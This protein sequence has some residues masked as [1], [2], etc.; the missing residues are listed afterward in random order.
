MYGYC[1]IPTCAGTVRYLYM[2]VLYNTYMCRYCTIPTCADTVR[3]LFG[4]HCTI[5]ICAGTVR[6]QYVQVL[7][8]TNMCRY[9]IYMCRYCTI[10]ICTGTVQYLHV[11]VLYDIYMCRYCT[12]STC[13][14]TVR[15]QY[16]LSS[17]P[18]SSTSANTREIS[19]SG[20]PLHIPEFIKWKY[21]LL[22]K[23]SH[24]PAVNLNVARLNLYSIW[25]DCNLQGWIFPVTILSCRLGHF[26]ASVAAPPEEETRVV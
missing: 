19:K 26:P 4:R 13:A 20:I 1:T 10:P 24:L 7:Y 21:H 3:Y 17:S 9:D 14:G 12:I 15:Y 5:P 18:C 23:L 6:Y 16:V 22:N 2:Q 8:N 25:F 11:Q